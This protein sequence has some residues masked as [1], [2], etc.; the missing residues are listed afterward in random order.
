MDG[1]YFYLRL[2]KLVHQ[3]VGGGRWM[4]PTTILSR[5][6]KYYNILCQNMIDMIRRICLSSSTSI[7]AAPW[8]SCPWGIPTNF[9]PNLEILLGFLHWSTTSSGV[10]WWSGLFPL[11]C[12]LPT[13]HLPPYYTS[14]RIICARLVISRYITLRGQVWSSFWLLRFTVIETEKMGSG[15]RSFVNK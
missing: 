8:C 6:L 11:G 2:L 13:L 14:Y 3:G 7:A 9:L 1:Y 10:C 12:C 4:Q 5:S 15:D